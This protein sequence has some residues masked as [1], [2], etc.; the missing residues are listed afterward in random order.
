MEYI[1]NKDYIVLRNDKDTK[2]EIVRN[3]II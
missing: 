1:T 3:D 2:Y